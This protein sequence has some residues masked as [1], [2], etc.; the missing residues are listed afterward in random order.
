M[1]MH[2]HSKVDFI[3]E[4]LWLFGERPAPSDL[5]E[6]RFAVVDSE[7]T[8]LDPRRDRL[9]SIGGV[10]VANGEIVIADSFEALLKVAYN[11]AS[12]TVHGITCDEARDGLDEPEA[13]EQFLHWLG[14]SVIVGHHIGHD[15]ATFDAAYERHFG[16]HLRNASLDTMD[17]TL[18]LE[19]GGAF[20]GRAEI[21]DFSLD[22][23][24][25]MFSVRPH[26][27]HTAAGDAFLTA[28]VFLRLYSLARRHGRTSLEALCETFPVEP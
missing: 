2:S 22:G 5:A 20:A 17:L 8:G 15:I 21:S 9:I 27:R 28:Q 11:A 6:V 14:D 10:A 1:P 18:H 19:K 7:M 23:L 4:Y 24:C 12:V 26:D 13:L 16:I 25:R 3:E